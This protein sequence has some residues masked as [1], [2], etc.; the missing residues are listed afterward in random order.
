MTG[1]YPDDTI[2]NGAGHAPRFAESKRLV[3]RFKLEW[4]NKANVKNLHGGLSVGFL[5]IS[6]L[7]IDRDT[8]LSIREGIR[9]DVHSDDT[10]VSEGVV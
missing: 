9:S 4:S 6:L 7:E 5:E 3:R 2:H 10:R 8:E 1:S